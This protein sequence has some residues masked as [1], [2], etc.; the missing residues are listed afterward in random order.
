MEEKLVIGGAYEVYKIYPHSQ[1]VLYIIKK[2]GNPKYER[3]FP[4]FY[5]SVRYLR[6]R[7]NF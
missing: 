7:N 5:H 4:A 1:T 2:E 6:L 3:D